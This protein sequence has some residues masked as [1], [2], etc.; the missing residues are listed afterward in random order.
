MG[1]V[2]GSGRSFGTGDRVLRFPILVLA[3]EKHM[4]EQREGESDVR[5]AAS[6]S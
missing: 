1:L 2:L 3:V 5:Q 6:G 4:L